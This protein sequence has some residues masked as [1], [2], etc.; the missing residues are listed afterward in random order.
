[1]TTEVVSALTLELSCGPIST[2][3]SEASFRSRP[4]SF[5]DSLARGTVGARAA[6]RRRPRPKLGLL[7]GAR[8]ST[9]WHS[10]QNPDAL[11]P[12]VLQELIG[13][14]LNDGVLPLYIGGGV[15]RQPLKEGSEPEPSGGIELAGIWDGGSHLK[16]ADGLRA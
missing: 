15:F 7:L 11:A 6:K 5:N 4:V 16:V 8:T 14:V 9:V 12:D 2:N 13:V 10:I 3:A 1:M